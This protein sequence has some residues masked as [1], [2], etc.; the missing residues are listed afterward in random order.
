MYNC[1]YDKE[2]DVLEIYSEMSKNNV[3][4][5]IEGHYGFELLLDI[6]MKPILIRIPEASIHFGIKQHYLEDFTSY[7]T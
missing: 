7:L 1:Q 3:V 5:T 6:N 2:K 4:E